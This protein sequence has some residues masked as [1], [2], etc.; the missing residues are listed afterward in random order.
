M[1]FKQGDLVF[2]SRKAKDS[3]QL[4]AAVHP[5]QIICIRGTERRGKEYVTLRYEEKKRGYDDVDIIYFVPEGAAAKAAK[6]NPTVRYRQVP[7]EAPVAEAPP[8]AE[9]VTPPAAE[10]VTTA[11]EIACRAAVAAASYDAAH[12]EGQA[13]AVTTI[14]SGL[15]GKVRI[16]KNFGQMNAQQA[17]GIK[18]PAHIE[19]RLQLLDPEMRVETLF[20]PERT[21]CKALMGWQINSLKKYCGTGAYSEVSVRSN[22]KDC[23]KMGLLELIRH[24]HLKGGTV[25]AKT[26]GMMF[27]F[28]ACRAPSDIVFPE[29]K[30][31][32][33]PNKPVPVFTLSEKGRLVGVISDPTNMLLVQK[34]ME[35]WTHRELDSLE[36]EK[37]VAYYWNQLAEIYNDPKYKPPVTHEF[38]EYVSTKDGYR[39]APHLVPYYRYASTLRSHWTDMRGVYGV[40]Y[41]KYNKSGHNESDPTCYAHGDMV[42][43]LMHWTFHENPIQAWAAKSCDPDDAMDSDGLMSSTKKS[44]PNK[45]RKRARE[46]ALHIDSEGDRLQALGSIYGTLHA[47]DVKNLPEEMVEKHVE[48]V[49]TCGKIL[50]KG[51][52]AMS[53]W[54]D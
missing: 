20:G 26:K 18:L 36:G 13:A 37:G 40:F 4:S 50:D 7:D 29:F 44:T 35:K 11:A 1:P 54:F 42:S 28:L 41:A 53:R 34:L 17:L 32:K 2:A 45:K 9:E 24:L 15:V 25:R 5:A 52:T 14:P 47:V 23:G 46:G 38:A 43:L 22:N 6:L 48:R 3:S 39:Y 30:V 19:A 8:T 31:P 16:P 10:G 21:A 12:D 27:F 51:I 33:T 49:R